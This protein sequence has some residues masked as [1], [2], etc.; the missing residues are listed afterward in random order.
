M[1]IELI[2]EYIV[3]CK[4]LNITHAARE[5]NMSQANLSKHLRQIENEVGTTLIN[6]GNRLNL[7]S[8][9]IHFLNKVTVL[10]E[11]YETTIKECR[12]IA[13]TA[14]QPIVIRQ[15]TYHDC[16]ASKLYERLEEFKSKRHDLSVRF[17]ATQKALPFELLL[18]N[19]VDAHIYYEYSEN[20][21]FVQ[22]AADQG[23]SAFFLCEEEVVAYCRSDSEFAAKGT[24]EPKDFITTPILKSQVYAPLTQPTI[25]YCTEHNVNPFFE[26]ADVGS[27]LELMLNEDSSALRILPKSVEQDPLAIMS[28]GMT[29][30]HFSP[31]LFART[32]LVMNSTPQSDSVRAFKE[33][34]ESKAESDG[35]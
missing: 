2:H 27:L 6:R 22:K 31:K 4:H 13:R 12:D 3:F 24:V 34:L 21:D 10:L 8:A 26:Y 29:T 18:S 1:Y 16:G 9:G 11:S 15:P 7:T 23:L 33:F 35:K 32:Y 28:S 25:D 14:A 30:V 5:L 17:T 19:R 20:T